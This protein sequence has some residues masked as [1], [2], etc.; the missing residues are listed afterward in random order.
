MATIRQV[1]RAF[2][3]SLY[4]ILSSLRGV[5]PARASI[6]GSRSR[7]QPFMLHL[8]KSTVTPNHAIAFSLRPVRAQLIAVAEV[9]TT[10]GA[11]TRAFI[12]SLKVP[13]VAFF[14]ST[15][16]P[17][18]PACT[19]APPPTPPPNTTVQGTT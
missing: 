10:P 7:Y 18:Q 4:F 15:T 13:G 9:G 14:M 6:Q 16:Q 5:V 19:S 1:R 2:F 12:G 8:P 17:T 11:T 3:L